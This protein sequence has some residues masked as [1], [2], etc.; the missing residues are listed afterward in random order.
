MAKGNC[1]A[2]AKKE[3]HVLHTRWSKILSEGGGVQKKET[4]EEEVYA[5]GKRGPLAV[6]AWI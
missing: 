4:K 5:V 3:D 1:P 2:T 6:I